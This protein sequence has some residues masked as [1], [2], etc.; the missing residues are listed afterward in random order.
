MKKVIPVIG[1][2]VGFAEDETPGDWLER[3]FGK[4]ERTAFRS[5]HALL[6]IRLSHYYFSAD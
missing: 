5:L 4:I 6:V 3:C 1:G 2:Y